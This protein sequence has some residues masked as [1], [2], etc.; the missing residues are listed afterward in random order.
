M[1]LT[2]ETAEF[3]VKTSTK[4]IKE[5]PVFDASSAMGRPVAP[6]DALGTAEADAQEGLM[7]KAGDF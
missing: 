1:V 6:L 2:F 4:S 7:V 3:R 5:S